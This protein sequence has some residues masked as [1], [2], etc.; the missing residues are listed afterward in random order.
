MAT[1]KTGL[2][3]NEQVLSN[4]LVVDMSERIHRLQEDRTQFTTMLME[5]S[6]KDATREIIDWLEE[7]YTPRTTALTVTTGEGNTVLQINDVLRM[8]E[9]GEGLLV[10]AVSANSAAITRSWGGTA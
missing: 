10:T 1:I 3:S 5:I 9:T 6:R 2:I 8:M 4:E 7:Q